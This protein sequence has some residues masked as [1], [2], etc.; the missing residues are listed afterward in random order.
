MTH[1]SWFSASPPTMPGW[2]WVRRHDSLCV[3]YFPHHGLYPRHWKQVREETL[4]A[5]EDKQSALE[6]AAID[7]KYFVVEYCGPINPP[8]NS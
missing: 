8:E 1:E 4:S 5:I 3:L 6:F 7:T 2:Y